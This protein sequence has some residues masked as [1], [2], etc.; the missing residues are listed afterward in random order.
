MCIFPA[1]LQTAVEGMW[2]KRTK[3]FEKNQEPPERRFRSNIGEVFFD[4]ALSAER[5]QSLIDGAKAA[6]CQHLESLA[7]KTT[8]RCKNRRINRDLVRRFTKHCMWP[9]L[10]WAIVRVWDTKTQQIAKVRLPM[11][12]PHEVLSVLAKYNDISDTS[13][14]TKQ[15]WEHLCAMRTKS[16]HPE[17]LAIG[18]WMDGVP[19][20]WDRK[21]TMECFSWNL[22]GLSNDK[23]KL[24]IPLTIIEKRYVA[25]EVTFNDILEVLA[26]SMVWLAEGKHPLRRHDNTEFTLQEDND[27]KK[28]AG[29]ALGC[30]GFLCELRGDWA[31]LKNTLHLAGWN[32]A[33]CCFR[34]NIKKTNIAQFNSD[35]PWRKPENRRDH[36]SNLAQMLR[37]GHQ[38]SALFKCPGFRTELIAI[39]WLHCCDLGV[40]AD[41][42]G[43]LLTVV[44]KQQP[45]SN[46]SERIRSLFVKLQ[47]WYTANKVTDRLQVLT[48]G[49]LR[50]KPSYSP[51]L[52]AYAAEVRALVP[53]AEYI[54]AEL[55]NANIV[56]N[57]IKQ[58][59]KHLH[60]C[61]LN[62]S[63]GNFSSISLKTEAIKFCTLYGALQED[64]ERSGLVAWRV[65]PKFHLFLEM[66]MEG[67]NPSLNWTYRDEDFGGS[68]AA[69]SRSKGGPSVIQCTAARYLMRFRAKHRVFF[70]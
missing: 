21:R 33:D 9:G 12:L 2:G 29:T 70:Y 27:R 56:H 55:D 11:L 60:K 43:N 65:K 46:I 67:H 20:N 5:V 57:T 10:Y 42:L 15:C 34:C 14:M 50:K 45:G 35:S 51:K 6:G 53:F 17:A 32:D 47:T 63:S 49:M 66:T 36:W 41:F 25:A 39:D 28:K 58:A 26:W 4:N 8:T 68:V 61:Y 62:L 18:F 7:T 30:F 1:F 19:C 69:V 31:L 3:E 40:A 38:P 59:A 22:P 16:N 48:E 54:S 13:G 64:A 37:D 44:V 23:K 24:R 52:R